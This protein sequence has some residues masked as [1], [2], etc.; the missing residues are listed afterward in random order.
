[1]SARQRLVWAAL[2]LPRLGVTARA[3][4]SHFL[5][6]SGSFFF[7]SVGIFAAFEADNRK[8]GAVLRPLSCFSPH[9]C[10]LSAKC[11]LSKLPRRPLVP[12]ELLASIAS[13]DK[14]KVLRPTSHE[15]IRDRSAPNL[16]ARLRHTL[17]IK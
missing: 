15:L 8:V 13:L 14:E 7:G 17:M 11:L 1:M 6:T 5:L 10:S 3:T 12:Q 16:D 4:P 9:P 2:D